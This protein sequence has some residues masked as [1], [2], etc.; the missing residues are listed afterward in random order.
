[1]SYKLDVARALNRAP[2]LQS[3][4]GAATPKPN[5]AKA[6]ALFPH[7]YPSA[8]YILGVNNG[9]KN[10]AKLLGNCCAA[11]ALEV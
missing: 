7:P 2:N 3:K 6:I 10:A 1:M 9:N 5:S 8:A 4:T 11:I